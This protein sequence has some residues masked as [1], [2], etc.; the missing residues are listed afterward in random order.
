MSLAQ[1]AEER[2]LGYDARENWLTLADAWTPERK[3]GFLYRLDVMKPLSVDTSV[4]PTIFQAEGRP[5]PP[6]RFGFLTTW[7]ELDALRGA[8]TR[9]YEAKR[10]RAWRMIAITIVNGPDYQET[11]IWDSVRP[12]VSPA[13]M[14]PSWTFLG[15]DVADRWL[16]SALS[17]CGFIAGLDDVA[18]L[19]RAYAPML[20]QFHLFSNLDHAIDFKRFSDRRLAGDHAPCF[21]FG[22][23]MIK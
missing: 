17:N 11:E 15:F 18:A 2:V 8:V 12:E 20:N 5:E 10:M 14:S 21:I 19:R 1:P 13:Q 23:W 16:L 22:L 7:S 4:W 3:E 6:E 9:A